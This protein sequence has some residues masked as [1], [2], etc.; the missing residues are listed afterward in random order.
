MR[1]LY[2][3]NIGDNLD[4]DE[5]YEKV[6]KNFM[7]YKMYIQKKNE[8]LRQANLKKELN[9]SLTGQGKKGLTGMIKESQEEIMELSLP[10]KIIFEN[11]VS[12]VSRQQ[13]VHRQTFKLEFYLCV[14]EARDL[15]EEPSV[16]PGHHQEPQATK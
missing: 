15:V 11:A 13:V 16:A 3:A 14:D 8:Q 10:F 7:A 5:Y 4:S 2:N 1:A 9:P 12:E 6:S